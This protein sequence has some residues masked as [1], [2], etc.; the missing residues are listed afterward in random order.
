[1]QIFLLHINIRL[2]NI[3]LIILHIKK[4]I[5]SYTYKYHNIARI[6]ISSLMLLEYIGESEG[7]EV[8]EWIGLENL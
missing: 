2:Y 7:E 1:M 6:V 8:E 3:H 4:D 5:L